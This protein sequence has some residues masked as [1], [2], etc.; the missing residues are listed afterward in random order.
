[1]N[2]G[3]CGFLANRFYPCCFWFHGWRR[4]W[5][6]L[7]SVLGSRGSE[8]RQCRASRSAGDPD[9]GLVHGAVRRSDGGRH[10]D[11]RARE[12]AVPAAVPQ[13][14]A[15]RAEPRHLQPG[16]SAARCGAVWRL[17]PAR[18]NSFVASRTRNSTSSG[19][20]GRGSERSS[21]RHSASTRAAAS[22]TRGGRPE[23]SMDEGAG[24]GDT[25]MGT[26]PMLGFETRHRT[27]FGGAERSHLPLLDPAVVTKSC[28]GAAHCHE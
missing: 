13:A 12:G 7:R 21:S 6:A 10:G 28:L 26:L 27:A 9:D 15:R 14:R 1:M 4:R 20:S 3:A 2:S 19:A 18:A 22:T 23:R 17:L 8:D 11:L 25:A 24:G 5:K 16:V